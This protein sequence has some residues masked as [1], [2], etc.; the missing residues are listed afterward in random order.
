MKNQPQIS[1]LLKIYEQEQQPYQKS[2]C[3]VETLKAVVNTFAS[4]VVSEYTKHHHFSL[5]A[6]ALMVQGMRSHL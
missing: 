2:I 5:R 6:T 1:T 4:I 3:L